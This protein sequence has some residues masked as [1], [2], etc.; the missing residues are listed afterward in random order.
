MPRSF[1]NIVSAECR[2]N[3]FTLT[4][5]GKESTPVLTPVSVPKKTCPNQA[6]ALKKLGWDPKVNLMEWI[7]EQ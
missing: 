4:Y 2:K 7:S 5:V 1:D 6:E 3:G